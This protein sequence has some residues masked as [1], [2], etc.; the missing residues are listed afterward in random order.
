[1]NSTD[2]QLSYPEPSMQFSGS[3]L[4]GI[5][6][7]SNINNIPSFM[8][9]N[10]NSNATRAIDFMEN[11]GGSGGNQF[12]GMMG[13]S[14]YASEISG[15]VNVIGQNYHGGNLCSPFGGM[16]L[17]SIN[18]PFMERGLIAYNHEGNDHVNDDHTINSIDVKPK[19][20]A[21]EWQDQNGAS[22]G[23]GS[24]GGGFMTG[25][26]STWGGIMNGFGP[27]ATNSMV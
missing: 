15:G 14:G 27:S 10:L 6:N 13:N 23:G 19:L 5:G 3:N 22:S 24:G 18:N 16:T 12:M 25:L 1:M 8:F 26:G 9:E 21:L 7:S 20:L 17:D 11:G 4:F 2:L